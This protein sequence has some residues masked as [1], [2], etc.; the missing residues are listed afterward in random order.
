MDCTGSVSKKRD[1]GVRFSSLHT[2]VRHLPRLRLRH[3]A[4]A[5]PTG[6]VRV[7]APAQPARGERD[8]TPAHPVRRLRLWS[9][10]LRPT[11]TIRYRLYRSLLRAHRALPHEM[12]SLGDDYVKAGMACL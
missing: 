7:G 11:R 8:A 1:G 2:R 4:D 10:L 6:R 3:A 5:G 12:R 9:R